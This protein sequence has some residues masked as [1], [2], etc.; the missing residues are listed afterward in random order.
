M[1]RL[2][3]PLVI[4]CVVVAAC[5]S[6]SSVEEMAD[7]TTATTSPTAVSSTE[8]DAAGESG[9]T[10]P[11]PTQAV[12]TLTDLYDMVDDLPSRGWVDGPAYD[13]D[14]YAIGA[15]QGW[16]P[17][18][19]LR[20]LDSD[21]DCQSDRTEVLIADAEWY[22]LDG[23]GCRVVDGEWIDPYTG[24]RFGT[25]EDSIEHVVAIA[26]VHWAGGWSWD[27]ERR[28]AFAVDIGDPSTLNVA[29]VDVNRE[30][31][32]LPPQDFAPADDAL[33]CQYGIDRVRIMTR[34]SLAVYDSDGERDALYDLLDRCPDGTTAP[35]VEVV[36]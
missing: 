30:K 18:P 8:P 36:P 7:D 13:Y 10:E 1:R 3:L 33:A 11:T 32:A 5:S 26:E 9:T 19:E 14:A 4:S 25:D 31:G 28:H 29:Q 6:D 23:S 27:R 22:E 21:G 15:E 35:A 12:L 17:L 24:E 20:D 34:W 2:L 16:P